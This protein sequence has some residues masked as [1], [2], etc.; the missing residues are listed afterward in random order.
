MNEFHHMRAWRRG[1]DEIELSDWRQALEDLAAAYEADN[2]FRAPQR[3]VPTPYVVRGRFHGDDTFGMMDC[4]FGDAELY[5]VW[6][7]GG[8]TAARDCGDARGF[9]KLHLCK[10]CGTRHDDDGTSPYMRERAKFWDAVALWIRMTSNP[11]FLRD[12]YGKDKPKFIDAALFAADFMREAEAR[13]TDSAL[14]Y[15]GTS[16][17]A[18][19][20]SDSECWMCGQSGA[21]WERVPVFYPTCNNY[22]TLSVFDAIV[23]CTTAMWEV[24][25]DTLGLARLCTDCFSIADGF[26]RRAD[27]EFKRNEA[28]HGA[29]SNGLLLRRRAA[30]A[31]TQE[32]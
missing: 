3:Y 14:E 21:L 28:T 20:F 22:D 12:L 8:L 19:L 32:R 13:E 23:T 25:F 29:L 10:F 7:A 27:E 26:V 4:D 24:D 18:H 15:L 30:F 1:A 11:R 31:E 6:A 16:Q 17:V 2:P 9:H 5:A